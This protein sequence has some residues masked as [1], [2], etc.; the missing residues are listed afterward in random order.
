MLGDLTFWTLIRA[1]VFRFIHFESE[2]LMMFRSVD[3]VDG[4]SIGSWRI[5]NPDGNPLTVEQQIRRQLHA[6]PGHEAEADALFDTLAANI[7]TFD[8]VRYDIPNLTRGALLH[9]SVQGLL[10]ISDAVVPSRLPRWARFPVIRLAHTIMAGCACDNFN[11]AATKIGFGSEI[12]VGAAFAASAARGWADSVS[13]YVMTGKF[14]SD[15][16]AYVEITPTVWSAILTFRDTQA[17]VNLRREIS[18][19][20]ATN[21]GGEFAAS[22]NAGL[23]HIVPSDVMDKARDELSELMFRRT[24]ESTVVPAVWINVRNS[25]AIARKWRERCRKE[26][27][28]HCKLLGIRPSDLCPCGSG[29]KLRDCCS[30]ALR[31]H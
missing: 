9:P 21:E 25:D 10:G 15:L 26:L 5:S 16:G 31:P 13:S 18:Q 8:D 30:R 28:A 17:G 6:T 14:N 20:L 24:K 3:A 4:G 22:V 7:A 23:R 29:E 27:E 1:G 19:E 2:P 12:L 11:L